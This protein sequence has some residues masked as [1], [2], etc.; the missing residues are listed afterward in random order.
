MGRLFGRAQPD[1]QQRPLDL[2]LHGIED[3]QIVRG[4]TLRQP[5]FFDRDRLA[6]LTACRD[7]AFLVGAWGEEIWDNDPYG[8]NFAGLPPSSSGN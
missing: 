2:F 1:D 7:P 4:D 8:R 5:A 6:T 3:F